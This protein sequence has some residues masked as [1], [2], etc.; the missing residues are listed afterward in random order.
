M[1]N[2]ETHVN[3]LAN[4]R[5]G[6]LFFNSGPEKAS[7]VVRA[8]FRAA[9]KSIDIYSSHLDKQVYSQSL[10]EDL[11]TR[12]VEPKNI[13]VILTEP[14][15][16]DTDMIEFLQRCGVSV[17][18]HAEIGGH[19]I[20]ADGDCYRFE[21][22]HEGKKAFF[23]FGASSDGQESTLS[24]LKESFQTMWSRAPGVDASNCSAIEATAQPA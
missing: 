1:L 9:R 10:F 15:Q 20:V 17:K 22:D 6:E 21:H 19:L 16:A 7:I 11:M 14:A 8:L 12:G 24:K 3:A 4:N 18:E 13:R 5:D 23:A 2:F